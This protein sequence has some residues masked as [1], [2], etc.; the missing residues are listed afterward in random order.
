MDKVKY[1]E[2]QQ[3]ETRINILKKLEKF[4]SVTF[5]DFEGSYVFYGFFEDELQSKIKE[6]IKNKISLLEQEFESL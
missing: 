2:A 3:I 6:F 4:N 1:Q 5:G